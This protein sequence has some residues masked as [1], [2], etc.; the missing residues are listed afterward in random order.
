[1]ALFKHIIKVINLFHVA[2]LKTAKFFIN[3]Y[4]LN[5][6]IYTIILC[7]V[8]KNFY[9]NLIIQSFQIPTLLFYL[10]D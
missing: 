8:F 3:K 6:H 5:Y 1:M 9:T 7:F 10:K 2:L 4:H